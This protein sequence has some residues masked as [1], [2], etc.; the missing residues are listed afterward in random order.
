MVN[1]I[2]GKLLFPDGMRHKIIVFLPE[3]DRKWIKKRMYR[4]FRHILFYLQAH[5]LAALCRA[6]D[7]MVLFCATRSF[8]RYLST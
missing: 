4:C 3:T 2:R 7:L 1:I 6:A 5:L 8:R